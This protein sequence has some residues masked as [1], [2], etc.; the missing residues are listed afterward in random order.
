MSKTV[1]YDTPYHKQN[2]VRKRSKSNSK[3]VTIQADALDEFAWSNALRQ[4]AGVV[5]YC[6]ITMSASIRGGRLRGGGVCARGVVPSVPKWTL[7]KSRLPRRAGVG[8]QRP[9]WGARYTVAGAS[10]VRRASTL[11]K[12]PIATS[13]VGFVGPRVAGIIFII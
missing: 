13:A 8:G 11:V 2:V 6:P 5:P 10:G 1:R 7:V 9:V 12:L 4:Y 3:C